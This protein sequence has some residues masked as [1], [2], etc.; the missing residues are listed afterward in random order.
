LVWFWLSVAV[1]VRACVR[2]Q[3][4]DGDLIDCVPAHLQPAFD[5]PRLRGQRPLV[6]GPPPARPKGNRLRDPIRNDTAEAAGV[7][8]LWAASGESCPEGSVPIRRVTESDVLRASSVRRFGRAPAGRVRRDSVSGGHEVR[9][10]ALVLASLT[11]FVYMSARLHRPVIRS[12]A[13]C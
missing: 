12:L 4:P 13:P 9:V 7:Q 1:C 6:A 2:M 3:S 11:S 8:Q 10:F 5:H